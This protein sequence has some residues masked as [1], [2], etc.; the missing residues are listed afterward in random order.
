M[1]FCVKKAKK[2]VKKPRV[3]KQV[4]IALP[5]VSAN[6]YYGSGEVKVEKDLD[7]PDSYWL[8]FTD[9]GKVCGSEYFGFNEYQLKRLALAIHLMLGPAK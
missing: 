7:C 5:C 2:A 1:E 6:T 8:A 4:E 3:K 9:E